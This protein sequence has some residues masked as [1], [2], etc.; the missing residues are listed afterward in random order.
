MEAPTTNSCDRNRQETT[1]TTSN[2]SMEKQTDRISVSQI[3][4][5]GWNA[6]KVAEAKRNNKGDWT[7]FLN[8]D[9]P[10]GTGEFEDVWRLRTHYRGDCR[11]LW[12]RQPVAMEVGLSPVVN[13]YLP[14]AKFEDASK[15]NNVVLQLLKR[16]LN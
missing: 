8:A 9:S 2:L 3:Y 1:V 6:N 16:C 12:C 15:F 13:K 10:L 14:N 5:L 4:F 11:A 7:V